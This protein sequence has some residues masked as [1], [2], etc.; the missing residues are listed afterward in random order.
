M[1]EIPS[2]FG[3]ACVFQ[4]FLLVWLC[5]HTRRLDCTLAL[6]KS[7]R[8][9]HCQLWESWIH[10]HVLPQRGAI[11]ELGSHWYRV[12]PRTRRSRKK[13]T[14]WHTKCRLCK[15]LPWWD[16]QG[17]PS[18]REPKP[19]LIHYIAKSIGSPP[20]NERFDYFSNFHEYKS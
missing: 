2:L 15:N 13:Q 7:V 20:S 19:S 17:F 16:H 14:P 3:S 4:C 1:R 18:H 9:I 12:Y 6:S 11:F 10:L 8:S 5:A